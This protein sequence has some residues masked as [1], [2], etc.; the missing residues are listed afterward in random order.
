[1]CPY[2]G[3]EVAVAGDVFMCGECGNEVCENCADNHECQ[4]GKL[5]D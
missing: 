5:N 1:M 4:G 2:C 3:A